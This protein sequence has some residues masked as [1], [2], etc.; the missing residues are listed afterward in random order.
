MCSVR[1]PRNRFILC[2]TFWSILTIIMLGESF[3]CK[4]QNLVPLLNLTT[5]LGTFGLCMTRSVVIDHTKKITLAVSLQSTFRKATQTAN[6]TNWRRDS[7]PGDKVIYFPER[8]FLIMFSRFL[9]IMF[10]RFLLI[11]L[12]SF[13][14]I[15][16]SPLNHVQS[17]LL[18]SQQSLH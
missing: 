10:T 2:P 15:K 1:G 13:L 3:G 5:I 18:L 17:S 12:S 4:S 11:K 7:A 14:L 9:L 16:F 8:I 6:S